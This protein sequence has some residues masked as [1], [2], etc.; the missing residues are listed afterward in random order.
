MRAIEASLRG[1]IGRVGE[2]IMSNQKDVRALQDWKIEV[3]TADKLR[4]RNGNGLSA[5]EIIK[6][7][8]AIVG[9]ALAVALA[10]IQWV[11]SK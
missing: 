10:A 7:T 3:V 6:F 8:L 2:I 1:E 9:P 11:S 5:K 4:G